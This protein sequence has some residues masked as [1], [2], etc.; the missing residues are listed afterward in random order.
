[1]K[2]REEIAQFMNAV[3]QLDTGG[4]TALKRAAGSRLEDATRALPA[5]YTVFPPTVPEWQAGRWFAAG[6]LRCLVAGN[7]GPVLPM[8][9][10][11]RELRQKGLWN[12]HLQSRTIQLLD[13]AWSD[14]DGYLLTKLTRFVKMLRQKEQYVDCGLL[15]EDLIRW[16]W[17]SQVVQHGWASIIYQ[18]K[19]KENKKNDV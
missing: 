13:T 1:M 19:E 8:P 12:D 3:D 14:E 2:Y 18:N 6:C 15:L 5:F 16:N 10:I 4:R 7:E 17:D 11:L 9:V